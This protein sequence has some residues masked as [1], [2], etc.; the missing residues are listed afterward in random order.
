ML[1]IGVWTFDIYDCRE[2]V[3]K[4]EHVLSVNHRIVKDRMK[5]V[6]FTSLDEG[7]F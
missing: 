5:T 4:T 7:S 1:C 3:K 2:S 6:Y